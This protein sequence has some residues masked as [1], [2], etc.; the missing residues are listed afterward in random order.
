MGT[1]VGSGNDIVVIDDVT[2]IEDDVVD[3]V[4]VVDEGSNVEGLS[5]LVTVVV[6]RGM[7]RI[8]VVTVVVG[9]KVVVV[10]SIIVRSVLNSSS[11][12]GV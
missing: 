10:V 3:S 2:F 4:E 5:I 12:I 8:T 7:G 1:V 11:L 6:E 9:F